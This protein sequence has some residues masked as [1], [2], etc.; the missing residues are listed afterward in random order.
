MRWIKTRI[1]SIRPDFVPFIFSSFWEKEE[2]KDYFVRNTQHMNRS[3]GFKGAA[4]R[5][6][7]P[8]CGVKKALKDGKINRVRFMIIT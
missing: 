5:V 8:D 7:E 2:L 3:A 1:S 4:Y 6:R